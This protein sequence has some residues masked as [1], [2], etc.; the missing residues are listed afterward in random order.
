MDVDSAF[1]KVMAYVCLFS[2]I[3]CVGTIEETAP[4]ETD[5]AE[6]L[7]EVINFTGIKDAFPIA[8]DKV[9]VVFPAVTG[10][11][12]D[13]TYFISY[14]GEIPDTKSPAGLERYYDGSY[15]HIIRGLDAGNEYLIKVTVKNKKTGAIGENNITLT[16]RTFT[17]L[18][19]NFSGINSVS[20]L[21]GVPGNTSLRVEWQKVQ[22][23]APFGVGKQDVAFYQ[24]KVLDG[25]IDPKFI[26]SDNLAPGLLKEVI[27][28]KSKRSHII[29]GLIPNKK[30]HIQVRAQNNYYIENANKGVK[31]EENV[32]FITKATLNPSSTDIDFDQ[33]SLTIAKGQGELGL[34]TVI[35]NWKAAVGGFNHYRLYYTKVVDA[36][37]T[38][39]V[40]SASMSQRALLK[41][42][43]VGNFG[44][45]PTYA[46]DIKNCTQTG[47]KIETFLNNAAGHGNIPVECQRVGYDKNQ[48]IVN[49]LEAHTAYEFRL[50]ICSDEPCSNF[51]ASSIIGG[52]VTTPSLADFEFDLDLQGPKSVNAPGE[53]ELYF[54]DNAM[55]DFD[56]GVL[57]GFI[58]A[59]IRDNNIYYINHPNMPDGAFVSDLIMRPYDPRNDEMLV[60]DGYNLNVPNLSYTLEVTPY[61]I[62]GLDDSNDPIIETYP[63]K[64]LTLESVSFAPLAPGVY[65]TEIPYSVIVTGCNENEIED[66]V[67]EFTESPHPE[68]MYSHFRIF[69]HKG[70]DVAPEVLFDDTNDEVTTVLVDTLTAELPVLANDPTSEWSYRVTFPGLA[71]TG[72]YTVGV[73]T[74]YYDPLNPAVPVESP[75]QEDTN[76]SIPGGQVA[77][78]RNCD[79]TL[80]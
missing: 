66:F 55:P 15:I 35:A 69:I 30:Y 11:D 50:V 31:H 54:K 38:E 42:D 10:S 5:N 1:I 59:E 45:G 60:F 18:T 79:H 34:S 14:D 75:D 6:T 9:A 63:A 37:D 49:T 57:D 12:E 62:K 80:L 44:V 39:P 61:I 46:A 70:L 36:D 3:S 43:A 26:N 68:G 20:N 33:E 7:Q 67:V 16:A 4:Q 72:D 17:D 13:I 73:K 40:G 47:V 65:N 53:F 64:K 48:M 51:Q 2:F 21:Q 27:V 71:K 28:S 77:N 76:P 23:V 74:Y 78:A 19:S 41:F 29:N 58:V 32:K 25:D 52:V 22:D 24:I 8:H 56:A